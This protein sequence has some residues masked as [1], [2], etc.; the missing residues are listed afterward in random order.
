M[1]TYFVAWKIVT[2]EKCILLFSASTLNNSNF[3]FKKRIDT[4]DETLSNIMIAFDLLAALLLRLINQDK[5]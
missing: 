3:L 5:E 2:H 4:T 1:I